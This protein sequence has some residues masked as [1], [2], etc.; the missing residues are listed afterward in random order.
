M[1]FERDRQALIAAALSGNPKFFYGGDSAPHPRTKKEAACAC[2]GVFNAPV[3]LALL[4]ELFDRYD[5]LEMLENF[6]SR[7]GAEFYGLPL[8]RSTIT[9]QKKAWRVAE[10]YDGIVP[11]MAGKE[12]SWSV[13]D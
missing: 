9:L 6:V 11:F 4:A 12:I 2:A 10:D 7:F 1:K 8:N 13:R 5:A 3:A